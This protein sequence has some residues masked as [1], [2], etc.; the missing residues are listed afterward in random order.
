MPVVQMPEAQNIESEA[1][2]TIH[3]LVVF[4]PVQSAKRQKLLALLISELKHRSLNYTLYPT[5]ANLTANQYY[6][7]AHLKE[8][9][10]V[11]ILGGDGTFNV[12]VNCIV[13]AQLHQ[14]ISH[15]VNVGL[16][17][18]GTGN[19]FSKQWFNKAKQKGHS[20]QDLINIVLG[21]QVQTLYLGECHYDNKV[22]YFNN[23]L[24]VGFDAV[25]AKQLAHQK[26]LFRSLSYLVAAL[27]HIPFY[28]EPK[29]ELV[30]KG[31]TTKYRNLITAFANSQYFGGGLPIA[32]NQ[33]GRTE[34][35]TVIRAP[36][37]SV[38]PKVMLLLKLTKGRHLSSKGVF[39][40][41]MQK[42]DEA[43]I[44]TAGLEIEADGEY[45]GETPC[46]VKVSSHTINLKV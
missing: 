27:R 13:D 11:V 35:L 16:L 19:D 4:N 42:E 15:K 10:D 31:K 36:K 6:F 45:I 34:S 43:E 23:V 37:L 7:K 25:I 17:P 20:Q 5:E 40:D 18:A 14:N 26:S 39:H 44:T 46:K 12:V 29:C 22:R 24:G 33:D 38:I 8:Y 9:T 21:N 30:F 1:H 3:Y 28:Q 32:P 2:T 41:K